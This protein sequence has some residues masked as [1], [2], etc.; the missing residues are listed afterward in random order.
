MK[1]FSLTTAV[2][3]MGLLAAC[4]APA[5]GSVS[6]STP[7]SANDPMATY[8]NQ[9]LIWGACPYDLLGSNANAKKRHDALGKRLECTVMSAPMNWSDPAAGTVHIELSR[10][11]ATDKDKR[12]GV[13][14]FNPGGPGGNGLPMSARLG[15]AWSNAE[16]TTE[17]GNQFRRLTAEYDLIGFAPRGVGKL[18]PLLCQSDK[19][20]PHY[21]NVS[22]DRSDANIQKILDGGKEIADACAK[23]PL[24]PYINTDATARDMDLARHLMG[25]K[26][27]NYLGYSYGTWLGDWYARLF[28]ENTGRMV[29]DS[30]TDIG[31]QTSQRSG[32][33]R[34][35]SFERSL[36]KVVL[37][38][39][40]RHP[41]IWGLGTN[42]EELYKDVINL[43]EP[44]RTLYRYEIGGSL[45][46]SSSFAHIGNLTRTARLLD[47]LIKLYPDN[48][49]KVLEGIRHIKAQDGKD[50]SFRDDWARH[51]VE[52]RR[53]YLS[54]SNTSSSDTYTYKLGEF[55]GTLN[56]VRCN[57][58][59]WN[60]DLSY[61]RTLGDKQAHDY[62]LFGGHQYNYV[63]AC[64][65]WNLPSVTKPAP[66]NLPILMV[67]SEYDSPTP[68]KNALEAFNTMPNAKMLFV[69]NEA[70]HGLFNYGNGCVDKVVMNYLLNGKLP[71]D[72]KSTCQGKPLPNEEK[73]Y[74][75]SVGGGIVAQSIKN[76]QR[77]PQEEKAVFPPDAQA[78][79]DEVRELIIEANQR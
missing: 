78:A 76:A 74:P 31:N 62:P 63:Q 56:A 20:L 11:R 66:H 10:V 54:R 13:L 30:N 46:S 43:S 34:G 15:Y 67:Q 21:Y 49:D 40:A 41:E 79:L 36:R 9:K 2:L 55:N 14:F 12:Q 64:M 57:D 37:P 59:A 6:G 47:T 16:E 68:A 5:S 35:E 27:L 29:L 65:Y 52:R 18:I 51:W 4:G 8:K 48:D 44:L 73:V 39:I 61:W 72:R 45:Y 24:T 3:S 77:L 69:D 25:E 28:P 17:V 50:G 58:G 60:K 26:K 22:G 7:N 19:K 32:L 38:Y 75:V 33:E 71:D 70:S 53:E 23:T 42:P 1:R